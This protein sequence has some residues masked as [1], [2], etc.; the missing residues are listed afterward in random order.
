MIDREPEREAEQIEEARQIA[1]I[2]QAACKSDEY[3][4]EI[5]FGEFRVRMQGEIAPETLRAVVEAL[6]TG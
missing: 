1:A 3:R 4:F 5:E 2:R 6:R